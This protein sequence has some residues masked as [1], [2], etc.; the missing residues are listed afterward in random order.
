MLMDWG[1]M[2]LG[3]AAGVPASL[4]FFA[5]LAWGMRRALRSTRPGVLLL[6][7]S[8]CRIAILL[9]VGFWIVTVAANPWPLAGYMLAFFVVRLAAV[10]WIKPGLAPS[11]SK[12]EGA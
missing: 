3:F 4:L 8:A 10:R 5:G 1:A 11:L 12:R 9:A 2:L 6:L 7:S